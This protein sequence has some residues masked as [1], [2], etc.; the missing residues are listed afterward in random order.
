MR[1]GR[2]NTSFKNVCPTDAVLADHLLP[3]HHPIWKHLHCNFRLR[4][5]ADNSSVTF[6]FNPAFIPQP[7]F[8]KSCRSSYEQAVRRL[9]CHWP[10]GQQHFQVRPVEKRRGRCVQGGAIHIYIYIYMLNIPVT[11]ILC[12]KE[13]SI[14]YCLW[15]FRLYMGFWRCETFPLSFPPRILVRADMTFSLNIEDPKLKRLTFQLAWVE[16]PPSQINPVL[17]LYLTM[18]IAEVLKISR[19]CMGWGLWKS[20]FAFFVH[21]CPPFWDDSHVKFSFSKG[22]WVNL[23]T[24]GL[25]DLT[26]ITFQ[27]S[28]FHSFFEKYT[29]PN[30]DPPAPPQMRWWAAGICRMIGRL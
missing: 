21:V 20:M 18:V 7:L 15:R 26:K 24:V 10:S 19:V 1:A 6:C 25:C 23:S 28:L 8:D 9:N 14:K 30:Q 3:S 2:S 5:F 13:S 17:C 29:H 22:S 4:A 12:N 11:W 27:G 16:W